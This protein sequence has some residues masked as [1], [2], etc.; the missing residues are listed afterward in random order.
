MDLKPPFSNP[1]YAPEGGAS[2]HLS[3]IH[4]SPH[5]LDFFIS[6]SKCIKLKSRLWGRISLVFSGLLMMHIHHIIRDLPSFRT[7]N[8]RLR[9]VHH[10]P[11][12]LVI[13]HA[14]QTV[15]VRS[16]ADAAP[17]LWNAFPLN[18]R[19]SQSLE[20]PK[21]NLDLFFDPAMTCIS[22]HEYYFSFTFSV[23][24]HTVLLYP[25]LRSSIVS[26]LRWTG[27]FATCRLLVTL[28]RFYV[29]T[30]ISSAAVLRLEEP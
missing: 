27:R 4:A 30:L 9:Q 28:S 26:F 10:D 19:A 22:S 23:C 18:L 29:Y 16:F 6:N 17:P 15:S 25:A 3:Q 11:L 7:C 5:T 21:R 2:W 24:I 1:A 13:P 12:P 14:S 20:Q 8:P